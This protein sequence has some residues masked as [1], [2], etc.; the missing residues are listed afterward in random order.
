LHDLAAARLLAAG[1]PPILDVAVYHCQQA[2][3]KALKGYLVY[4]DQRVEKTHDIGLWIER[5]MSI[6]PEFGTMRDAGDHLTPFATAYRYPGLEDRP[7]L[8]EFEE[9][10]DE[11]ESIYRHVLSLLPPEVHPES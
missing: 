2:A 7:E 8:M 10:V 4:Q 3:E 6:E 9:A 5:A 1:R 11:A